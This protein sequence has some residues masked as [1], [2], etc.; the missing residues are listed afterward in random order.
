EH[1]DDRPRHRGLAPPRGRQRRRRRRHRRFRDGGRRPGRR[2]DGRFCCLRL[3][4]A[5][6]QGVR[7]AEGPRAR[8]GRRQ[9]RLH[10]HRR[11]RRGRRR[12]DLLL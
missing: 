7:R 11:S 3:V 8:Q 9:A 6:G 10:R 5:A 12:P 1:R 2:G 4:R